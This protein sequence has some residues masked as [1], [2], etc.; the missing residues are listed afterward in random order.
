MQAPQEISEV[1]MVRRY[2]HPVERVWRAWTQPDQLPRWFRPYDNVVME[3]VR[4]D[5]QEGGDYAYCFTWPESKF[6]LEGRFLSVQPPQCLIFTWK[7][8]PP[9]VDA[10]KDTMVS[11]FLR[12]ISDN[13][14]EVEVR[15]TLFPDETMR[16]RHEGCWS[17]TLDQL[18]RN[19]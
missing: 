9:D 19:L 2:A 13:E 5:F 14:T 8:L 12:S 6:L 1:I 16:Q 7:P 4:F 17:A 11:V 18:G 15:H 3:I 10:G